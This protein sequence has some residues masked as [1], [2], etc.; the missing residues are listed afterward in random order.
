[1]KPLLGGEF[2]LQAA[3]GADIGTVVCRGA[4]GAW[5]LGPFFRRRGGEP[6]DHLV[7]LLDLQ[8]R[9]AM[10]S[11]GDASLLD[12]LIGDGNAHKPAAAQN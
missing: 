10:V 7:M 8:A 1:M 2:A 11:V 5:G 3:D 12:S 6:G 4:R 9:E